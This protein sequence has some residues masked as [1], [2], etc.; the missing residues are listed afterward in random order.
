MEEWDRSVRSVVGRPFALMEKFGHSA[1]IVQNSV[2]TGNSQGSVWNA[3]DQACAATAGINGPAASVK[4]L[5]FVP[6]AE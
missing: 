1:S 6:M 5:G 3:V 4:Q 2:S